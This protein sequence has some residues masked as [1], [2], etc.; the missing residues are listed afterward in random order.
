LP[1]SCVWGSNDRER[2][3]HPAAYAA[4]DVCPAAG[5][6]DFAGCADRAAALCIEV[7]KT[8]RA[9]TPTGGIG[10]TINI[11]TSR[12]LENPGMHANVGLK[13]VHDASNENLP[14][15]VQGDWLTLEISGIFSNT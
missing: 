10:A 2:T 13:G 3:S 7:F 11:K 5:I 12:P 1:H 8:S 6:G 9:S 14:G 4:L 15:R